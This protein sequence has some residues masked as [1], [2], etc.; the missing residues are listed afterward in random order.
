GMWPKPVA[1]SLTRGIAAYERADWDE[2]AILARER[3]KEEPSDL[4]AMRLLARSAARQGRDETAQSLYS[5][6]GRPERGDGSAPA[7]KASSAHSNPANI[8]G[9]VRDG[10]SFPL[11]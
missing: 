10:R 9:A 2:A 3:L 5:R 1:D 7:E 8:P 6:A 11:K 4:E